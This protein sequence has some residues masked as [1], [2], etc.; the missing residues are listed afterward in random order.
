[1]VIG[2]D[3]IYMRKTK[4]VNVESTEQ[5]LFTVQ[6]HTLTHA[7]HNKSTSLIKEKNNQTKKILNLAK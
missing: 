7:I 2:T 1:L 3:N 4:L 5:Y 6:L